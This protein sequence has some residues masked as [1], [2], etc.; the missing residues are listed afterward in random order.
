VWTDVLLVGHRR[1]LV[2]ALEVAGPGT[3][4]WHPGPGNQDTQAGTLPRPVKPARACLDDVS[5]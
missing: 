5:A 1:R 3:E 4:S 2:E